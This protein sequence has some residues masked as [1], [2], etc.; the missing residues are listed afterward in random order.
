MPIDAFDMSKMHIYFCNERIGANK[1]YSGALESF[2]EACDVPLEQVHK[3]PEAPSRF[4]V[5]VVVFY[6]WSNPS[7]IRKTGG[8]IFSSIASLQQHWD[9]GRAK[10]FSDI[11]LKKTIGQFQF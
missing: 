11:P 8:S 6:L 9:I 7:S 10:S 1:C 4:V 2:V 5:V 3:V